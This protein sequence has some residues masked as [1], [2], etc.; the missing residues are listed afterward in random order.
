MVV[1]ALLAGEQYLDSLGGA[2]YVDKEGS[3]N[4]E[5]FLIDQEEY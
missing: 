3:Y 1:V 2:N 4:R 5:R